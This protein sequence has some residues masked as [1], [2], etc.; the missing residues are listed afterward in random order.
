MNDDRITYRGT[1]YPWH[2]D[3]MGHMNVMWYVSKF[4]EAHWNLMARLGITPSYMRTHQRG[5]AALEQKIRYQRELLA[6]D[7]VTV[8]STITELRDKVMLIRQ[9][10]F[11]TEHGHEAATMDLV[12][13]HLDRSVRKAVP[14]P[15]QVVRAAA[16]F[17]CNEAARSA[18]ARPAAAMPN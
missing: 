10:M 14:L 18:A 16:G 11:N 12:A 15:A 6:G 5:M 3:H 2:C 7:V 4:D 8:Q 13:V 9:T 17:I 1:V